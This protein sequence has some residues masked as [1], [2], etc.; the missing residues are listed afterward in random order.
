MRKFTLLVAALAMFANANAEQVMLSWDGATASAVAVGDQ[1]AN[2]D[3]KLTWDNGFSMILQNP[4]KAYASGSKMT[5]NGEQIAPIKLSN[6][7]ENIIYLPAGNVATKL[8][9][10]SVINKDAATDRPCYYSAVNEITFTADDAQI[11]KSYKDF[12]NP[13]TYIFEITK[14]GTISFKNTGEQPFV[15]LVIDYEKGEAGIE[16]VIASENENAPM[17]NLQGVQVDENYKGI[18]IKN[19]KKFINK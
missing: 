5:V 12:E 11:A 18:V 1:D 14:A 8:T 17:Y 7:A 15:V 6:G 9:I 4:A 13:D 16:N 10:Y 3:N 2:A 19:G